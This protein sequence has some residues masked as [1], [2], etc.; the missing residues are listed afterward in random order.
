MYKRSENYFNL[1]KADRNIKLK[2]FTETVSKKLRSI[3]IEPREYYTHSK[4]RV[5]TTAHSIKGY[6]IKAE[7][8]GQISIVDDPE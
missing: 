7:E 6:K 2:D 3:Y 4:G 5:R 8:H 1:S